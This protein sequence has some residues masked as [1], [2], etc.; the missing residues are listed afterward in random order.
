MELK[1][2]TAKSNVASFKFYSHLYGIE[3]G[4]EHLQH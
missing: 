3:I 4:G 1:F 2:L